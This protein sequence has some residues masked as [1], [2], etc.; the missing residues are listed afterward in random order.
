VGLQPG[1]VLDLHQ[2]LY[3]AARYPTPHFRSAINRLYAAVQDE[4]YDAD[5]TP[6]ASPWHTMFAPA[7]SGEEFLVLISSPLY[8]APS[9]QV[10]AEMVQTVSALYAKTLKAVTHMKETDLPTP[11]GFIYLDEPVSLTDVDGSVLLTRAFSWGP[12]TLAMAF[13]EEPRDSSRVIVET[14]DGVRLTA[15]CAYEDPDSTLTREAMAAAKFFEDTP[16][17]LSHSVFVPFGQQLAL[18]DPKTDD[19][20]EDDI[21]RWMHTLWMFMETEAVV[22]SRPPVERHARKR[23]LRT[24]N[25]GEVRVV[26]LR[27]TRSEGSEPPGSHISIEW[28]CRWVVQGHDRHLEDYRPAY[29]QHEARGYMDGEVR[30]C[31]VCGGRTTFV[32]PYIKG[33]DGLPLKAP[34]GELFK[35]AR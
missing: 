26:M 29:G 35:V 23:G 16:L 6:R 33:P 24:I 27:R 30:R 4:M 20:T 1:E 11:T 2:R 18:R 3:Q 8:G 21:V 12:Q 22:A 31:R 28:S 25:Q 34:A 17:V 10:T 5:G 7:R 32:R 19:V 9:Y 15:W 13:R 14:R